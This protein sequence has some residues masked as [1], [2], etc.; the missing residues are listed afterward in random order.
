MTTKNLDYKKMYN[1]VLLEKNL[2]ESKINQLVWEINELKEKIQQTNTVSQANM[3]SQSNIIKKNVNS[4]NKIKY[5]DWLCPK[6]NMLIYGS[7]P[8]CVKC[9]TKNP[10]TI[11]VS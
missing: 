5:K 11:I 7:K 2:L 8:E 6:C 10:N 3:S 1:D 9:H 4:D